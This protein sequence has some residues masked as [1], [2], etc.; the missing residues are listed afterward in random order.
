MLNTDLSLAFEIGNDA[1]VNKPPPVGTN[2]QIGPAATGSSATGGA[3][4]APECLASAPTRS[5]VLD[6]ADSNERWLQA[7]VPAWVS[8]GNSVP[9]ARAR[10]QR[11]SSQR[12]ERKGV[13]WNAR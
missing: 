5:A 9:E 10:Q 4:G 7:Y 12:K 8:F 13:R 3:G 2:C 6:F 11:T 1:Q